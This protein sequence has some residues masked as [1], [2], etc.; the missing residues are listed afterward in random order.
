MRYV[1]LVLCT[2]SNCR[3]RSTRKRSSKPKWG[4]CRTSLVRSTQ[5]AVNVAWFRS[6]LVGC[7]SNTIR[8]FCRR[9]PVSHHSQAATR[10]RRSVMTL[11]AV[12]FLPA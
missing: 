1:T 12:D 7:S 9:V 3:T 5:N 4:T 8:K 11:N 10:S 2:S 6:S